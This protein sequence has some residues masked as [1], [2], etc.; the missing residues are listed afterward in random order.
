MILNEGQHYEFTG[1]SICGRRQI[2]T[3]IDMNE[4]VFGIKLHAPSGT[5]SDGASIPAVADNLF[6]FDPLRV[7]YLYAAFWHDLIYANR[8]Y[9][10]WLADLIFLA[11]QLRTGRHLG[12]PFYRRWY[13]SYVTFIAVRGGGPRYTVAAKARRCRNRSNP[14]N[15]HNPDT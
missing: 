5:L 10:R 12:H 3:I 1:R 15:N 13:Y 14:R 4:K 9:S 2:R 8:L 7:D 6:G 11:L